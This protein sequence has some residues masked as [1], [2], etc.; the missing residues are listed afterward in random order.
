MELRPEVLRRVLLA[1]S[2]LS[3][4]SSVSSQTANDHVI[5]LHVLNAHDAADLLFAAIADHQNK[6]TAK[7]KSPAMTECLDLIDTTA[8]KHA[9]YFKQLNDARNGLKH[10]G[11]LPNAGQWAS[12]KPDVFQKLTL[13]CTDCFGASLDQLDESE[14]MRNEEAKVFFLSAKDAAVCE[15]YQRALEELGKAL[16]VTLHASS[17][18]WEVQVGV[19]K[20]ED[21]LKLSALGISAHEFLKLQE[22]LPFVYR[23]EA[24]EVHWRQ[25]KFGH[26]ANWRK[27]SADFCINSYLRIAV[28]VENAAET[29]H[30][31]PFEHAYEYRVTATKDH[32]EVWEEPVKNSEPGIMPLLRRKYVR[33]MKAGESVVVSPYTRAFVSEHYLDQDKVIKRVRI[34]QSD[35]V[36]GVIFEDEKAQFVNRNDVEILCVPRPP[37]RNRLPEIPFQDD[38][39]I[40]W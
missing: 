22:F 20:A 31:L 7:G 38:P 21:A 37:F 17:D 40:L 8:E 28:C 11:N 12:V 26:P 1:K 4:G 27:E 30:A 19:A 6:L 15:D 24:F 10:A 23:T 29:P 33:H 32:A 5:A 16:L 2:L 13:L 9:G 14:L 34:S 18:F 39:P 25:G 3:A 36:L 35:S